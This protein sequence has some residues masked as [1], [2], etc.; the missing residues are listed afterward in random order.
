MWLFLPWHPPQETL[1]CLWLLFPYCHK[2]K[3]WCCRF[4]VNINGTACREYNLHAIQDYKYLV[5]ITH[6]NSKLI[7]ILYILLAHHS[8]QH[9]LTNFLLLPLTCEIV[10][11][12][13][14]HQL[15]YKNRFL[16]LHP[17]FLTYSANTLLSTMPTSARY[18]YHI[19]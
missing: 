13:F 4:Y 1:H 15:K 8:H 9:L 3:L 10:K 19:F 11:S 16:H 2:H 12:I 17:E 18:I 7:N 14:F 5:L 6:N